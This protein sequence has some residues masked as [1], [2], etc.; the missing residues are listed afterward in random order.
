MKNMRNPKKQMLKVDILGN[1]T[2]GV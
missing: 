1:I 2:K